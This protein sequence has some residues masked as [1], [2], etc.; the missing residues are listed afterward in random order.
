MAK[1]KLVLR[2]ACKYR[3]PMVAKKKITQYHIAHSIAKDTIL[4]K[5]NLYILNRYKNIK[6]KNLESWL[7]GFGQKSFVQRYL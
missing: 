1:G 5:K 2:V 6:V 4:E 7:R 3:F